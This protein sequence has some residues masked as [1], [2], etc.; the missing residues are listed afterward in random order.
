MKKAVKEKMLSNYYKVFKPNLLIQLNI[1]K[2][3]LIFKKVRFAESFRE[4]EYAY[5]I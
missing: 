2:L 5:E 1:L 4:P 3:Y